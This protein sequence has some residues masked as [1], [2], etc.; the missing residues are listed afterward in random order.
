M[1]R[2]L[3]PFNGFSAR[4]SKPKCAAARSRMKVKRG[5]L[6][7]CS[8]ANFPAGSHHSSAIAVKRAISASDAVDF[9]AAALLAIDGSPCFGRPCS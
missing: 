7:L 2:T 1:S 4:G 9:P 3:K 5:G 8:G 6:S